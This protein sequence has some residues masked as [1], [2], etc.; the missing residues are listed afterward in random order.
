M[1]VERYLFYAER[2]YAKNDP[3]GKEIRCIIGNRN[4]HSHFC[5]CHNAAERTPV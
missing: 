3:N 4:Q 2:Y 5:L 1:V